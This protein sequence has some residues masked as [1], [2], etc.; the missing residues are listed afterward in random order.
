[1][2]SPIEYLLR[3]AIRETCPAR[4]T[5]DDYTD[6][7]GWVELT[8]YADQNKRCV[9]LGQVT[10]YLPES[11]M[12]GEADP[13]VSE[14]YVISYSNIKV[15]TY[16]TDLLFNIQTYSGSCWLVVECDGHEFHDRTKQQA[17]YDRSRDR[18]LLRLGVHTIR[19]TGS[20][21]HHSANRCASEVWALI[22]A[23]RDRAD[24]AKLAYES[25]YESGAQSARS[26]VTRRP[27]TV[28]LM[29]ELG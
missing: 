5:F 8:D 2:K 17:A 13:D 6:Q 3:D 22:S 10:D 9:V 26:T 1:M 24:L 4:T 28:G 23:I 29:S 27:V 15:L 16:R 12:F 7:P 20:E 21:I 19:F 11:L 25:G 18:E 14:H